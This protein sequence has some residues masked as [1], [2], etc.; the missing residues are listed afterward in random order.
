MVTRRYS[1]VTHIF[2][3]GSK[4]EKCTNEDY[5][6][7]KIQKILI[8]DK[9]AAYCEDNLSISNSAFTPTVNGCLGALPPWIQFHL[10]IKAVT[11]E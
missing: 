8:A 4:V 9:A 2:R 11:L 6:P 10:R 5:E 7:I 3:E 1:E